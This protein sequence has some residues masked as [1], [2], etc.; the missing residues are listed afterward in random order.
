[1]TSPLDEEALRRWLAD[2]LVTIIGCSPSD[3]DF[4]KSLIDLGLASSDAIVLSGELSELLGRRVSPVE[5]WQHPSVGHLARFLSGSEPEAEPVIEP[6]RGSMDESIAVIGLGCRFPGDIVGPEALWQFLCEGR[7]AVGEVPLDRWAPFGS[8]SAEAEAALSGTTRW[9]SFLTEIDAFDADFFEIS[10]REAVRMDP[11]Q[12]LLL[13]VAWEALEHA[14]LPADSLRRTQTGVFV[15]ACLAEY[16]AMA[17]ADLSQVDAWSGTGGALSVIA[18]RVSYFFD[19]RGPSVTV[20][21][22]CSSSLVAVHLAC[23]SLRAGDSN[24]TLVA[25]VNL[26]LS[27][28][29]TR[30]FDQAEAMSP[31]GQCHAFDA[32]ADGFVRGEGCGVAVLKRLSDA[33][34]DGDRVLAV[35]R[36]SAVNQDGRSNGLMAPNPAAQMAVLRAA[37]SNAGVAPQEVDYVE[38]HGTGTLLGDPIEARALGTVL[39]RARPQSVPLL[40]GAVKSNLGHLEAAAGIAGFIKTVLSLQRGQIPA[41]L[42]FQ[43]P[44]PHIPFDNLHLKVVAQHTVWPSTEHPRRAGVSSFGFGGTNAHV[45]LEQGPDPVSDV[46]GGPPTGAAVTTLVVSGKTAERVASTAG[47]LAEWMD[48]DGAAV[49]LADVAHTLNHHR[50]RHVKLATV[51][52]RD[53][54]QAVAG[55]RALADGEPALGVV[56]P[57]EGRHGSG[58]VFVY[59]GQ[60]SQWAGMGQR[61]LADEPAFAAAVAELEPAF[62]AQTGF[63][64]QQ[65]LASGEPLVGIARIQPALVGM[66]LALTKLWR[67][68]GVEPDAVI[69]H[70]MGEVTAAVVAGALTPAEGLRVIATRSRLMSRM[71]GQGAMALLEM[72]AEGTAALIADYP[73]VT[74]A[75]YASPSQTVVA[76]PSEQVDAVIAVVEAEGLLAR[77]IEVDV[78]S[79][80]PTIDP[81][82][83]DLR[84]A[85]ADLEPVAPKIPLISTAS[86]ADDEALKFDADYW[87]ANLRSPVRFSQAVAAAAENHST[88]IEVSPHPLL[89]YAIGDTLASTFPNE[90]CTVTSVMKRG[91]DETLSLHMQLASL[92]VTAPKADGGRPADVPP[93]PW[94]HSRYWI[95][96]RPL[97]RPIADVHPLLGVHVEMPSGRDHIWQADIGTEMMP[98]LAD[99]RVNR[100]TVMPVAGFAEM[101]FAAGCQALSL[102]VEAVE[103]NGLE[104]EQTLPLDGQTRVTTQL[105]RSDDGICIQIHASSGG[106]DWRRYAVASVGLRHEDAQHG[107]PE[108]PDEAGTGFSETEIMLSDEAADHA[109]YCIHP[110]MLDA[111]LTNLAA[112]LPAESLEASSAY[113]P[114]S[115]A[116]IR[117]FGR[118]GRRARCRTEL[119]SHEH[120]GGSHL[121]RII[122]L[123][124]S[125][126][127]TA[128]LTGVLL[129]PIDIGAV[130]LALEQKVFETIWV[131]SSMPPEIGSELAA[132]PAG[133]WLLLVDDDAETKA[134]VAEFTARLSSPTR[135]VVDVELSNESAAR[136]AVAKAAADPDLQP[137]GVIVFIGERSFDGTYSDGALA[138]ARELIW[139][140][141]LA[142]RA[143]VDGWHGDSP[144]LWLV[145]RNG[146]AVRGDE[147]GDPAVGA[148]KG[149]I[150]NWRFP[151]EAARFLADEPDIGATLVDVDSA[152]GVENLVAALMSELESPADDD[153]VAWRAQRRY[154][155]R[156]S[157]ARLDTGERHA[158]VRAD[159]SYI[160]TGG[161]GGLGTAV[162]RWLAE[163]GAGRLILNGRTDPSAG[164]RRELDELANGAEILFV[165]G[166]IASPGV[167][168]R[169]VAAAE[170][171]GR[172]LRGV[173]H[174]AG[175]INDG[176][177]ATLT[178][179]GLE[180]VWGPKAAG[181][182]R[183]QEATATRQLDWWV[184]FSSMATLLGLPGQLAY[185]TANAWL[186]ALMAWRRASSLPATAVNWGQWSD[187]GMSRALTYSILD[188]ITPDE[189]I[190]AL[191][192]LVGGDLIRVGVG[193]L[194]LDRAITATPEFRELG[195][196]QG[197]VEEFDISSLDHRSFVEDGHRSVVSVPDWSQLSTQDRLSEVETR[198]RTIL[199]RELGMSPSAVNVD[200]PFP[201]LGLDSMMAMMVLRETRK[202]VGVELSA[203]MLF[204]HPTIASLATHL[205]ETLAAQQAPQEDAAD[206]TPDSASSVLDELFDQVESASAG[207]ESGIF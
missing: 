132:A 120:D 134:L 67:S 9:G 62:A 185:T 63:S 59:S 44:N 195:Y 30:S 31:T 43:N 57:H 69:G 162:A 105:E 167:A 128:E 174:A 19:L 8:G 15:G 191:Q 93:S 173:V 70:S 161:L 115:L 34:R 114:V 189:G 197:L 124:D 35:V 2:Y 32:A 135:R 116:T 129:R 106:G 33:L 204:N 3:I 149:L 123:D 90:R 83:P 101:A 147:P 157:R 172:P 177:V 25:G 28:V 82:L 201:E 13:E 192:S 110:A 78:A 102:P 148:L 190:E 199:A 4:D 103:V 121:G 136:E 183:L 75:V 196:F 206:L 145:T 188:P 150:R 66:Q 53:R 79:H 109:R 17:T 163:R 40:I 87:A 58:T 153:V 48:G 122:L 91:E 94:L 51:C 160:V 41:N 52:A 36:G 12:R 187:V 22:A 166:D 200:K 65:V 186:D 98:W 45:V 46:T 154:V 176:L 7:S 37:L 72:D 118:V 175:V 74:L 138:R 140:V 23:Q 159:G 42:N 18:N 24:L 178:R 47:M 96:N 29:V 86:D 89:T 143:V 88:F 71:A 113:L 126:T 146:L 184:G 127:V 151:G 77:R 55:L 21:T 16:G 20:D 194:R 142:A 137:V 112:A 100:Q 164:K 107:R 1:M 99:H 170:E 193:R 152:D 119:V 133:S 141:S 104:V 202:V 54:A 76:G 68:Y 14:G 73:A 50:A 38:A 182:L 60:G 171:T 130:P 81:I 64:L 139:A 117:V 125:G 203:N 10:P 158:V 111:A 92:G 95:E 108:P 6:D 26:M 165:S 49:A 205:A 27:P 84:S 97:A 207:G 144:R 181:A 80:H 169:L 198:L 61:L 85:L 155:E 180:R 39:G 56:E 5:F 179:E 131:E 156:L 168:D 11:Q